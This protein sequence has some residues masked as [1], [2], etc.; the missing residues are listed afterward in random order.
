[1]VGSRWV[2]LVVALGMLGGCHSSSTTVRGPFN[3]SWLGGDTS[4]LL[5]LNLTDQDG[6]VKGSGDISGS[7]I[8]GGD[9]GFSVSGTSNGNSCE[10]T[11][12]ATGLNNA[13]MGGTEVQADTVDAV[14]NG[15]GFTSYQIT[16]H[17]Q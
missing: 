10:L 16:L 6:T 1:M 8:S 5:S 7:S 15:S 3:G 4:V 17:R 9:I 11:L 12:H 2:P 13:T 14:L